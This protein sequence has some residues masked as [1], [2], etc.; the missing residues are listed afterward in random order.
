[1]QQV[2]IRIEY[3][4]EDRD[5]WQESQSYLRL[6]KP[7]G[8]WSLTPMQEDRVSSELASQQ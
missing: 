4:N 6:D 3:G 7:K 5:R 8:R 1:M 2:T